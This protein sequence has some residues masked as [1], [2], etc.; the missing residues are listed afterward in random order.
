[1]LFYKIEEKNRYPVAETI[2]HEW[3]KIKIMQEPTKVNHRCGSGFI[4]SGSEL[5]EN[6]ASRYEN[7]TTAPKGAQ[8]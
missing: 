8:I 3:L 5:S 4:F 1:M 6:S 7:R 2:N